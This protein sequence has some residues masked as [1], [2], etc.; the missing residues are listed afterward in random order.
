[1]IERHHVDMDWGRFAYRRGGSG[2]S[3]LL[4]HSLALSGQMWELIFDEFGAEHDLVA[5]DFRGH[6]E[7]H[8]DG[9]SFSVADLAG[10]LDRLLDQLGVAKAH[11]LG[12]SMGGSVATVFAASYPSRV[13]RLTLCDTTA[14]YGPDAPSAWA[15]RAAAAMSKPREALIPFQTDRWFSNRFLRTSPQ[16]VSKVV[17]IFL[18]TTPR[19]HADG[20]RA[21]GALDARDML[22]VIS[23]PTLVVT[24]EEDYATPSS[25]GE[26]LQ[27]GIA[28][29]TFQVWPGLRHFAILESPELR[30]QVLAHFR[31]EI[32]AA[33]SAA[34]AIPCCS[35]GASGAQLP[36][37][38]TGNR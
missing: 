19:A 34:D 25:M 24:G 14:W 4:L 26:L 16:S 13:D 18:R 1:M 21:L 36:I 28:G 32:V 8:D 15:E 7:S 22:G 6:G 27:E 9:R 37:Y 31:G 30:R 20:C 17:R 29:A 35:A 38:E 5:V 3:L 2:T 23:A 11:V 12:M 10:D 33:P